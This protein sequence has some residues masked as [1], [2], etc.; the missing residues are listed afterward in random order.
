MET[1][2]A[3]SGIVQQRVVGVDL[4]QSA[5]ASVIPDTQRKFR[6]AGTP[7]AW[8]PGPANMWPGKGFVVVQVM[9]RKGE[10]AGWP[11]NPVRFHQRFQA[12][13]VRQSVNYIVGGKYEIK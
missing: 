10:N 6:Y 13:F 7:P 5:Y 3:M 1:S 8:V 12:A 2:V 4:T 11:K 9:G